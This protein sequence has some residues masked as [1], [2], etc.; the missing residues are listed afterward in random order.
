PPI[1][2]PAD[3]H[4]DASAE[5]GTPGAD[6]LPDDASA[7]AQPTD[8]APPP[9]AAA[10]ESGPPPTTFA[11]AMAEAA[12]AELPPIS[13]EPTHAEAI[14]TRLRRGDTFEPDAMRPIFEKLTELR[15][16]MDAESA[17]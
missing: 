14:L 5:P 12:L 11:L 6:S 13:S 4:A 7:S 10:P 15:A 8:T 3:A 2:P 17:G 9:E 16:R 1:T